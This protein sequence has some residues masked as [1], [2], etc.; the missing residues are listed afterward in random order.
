MSGWA[1]H[2]TQEL[3][4]VEACIEAAITAYFSTAQDDTP[5]GPQDLPRPPK[6]DEGAGPLGEA[7]HRA[8]L[9]VSHRLA[10]GLALLPLLRPEALDMFLLKNQNTDRIFS[11]FCLHAGGATPVRP[12]VGTAVF[13]AGLGHKRQR[14]SGLADFGADSPLFQ[15]HLLERPK[16][17]L[18]ELTMA[19][20]IPAPDFHSRMLFDAPYRP[21]TREDFPAKR[22]CSRL[23][24]D[25]LVLP[26]ETMEALHEILAWL[27]H[28]ETILASDAGRFFTPGYRS[29]FFGPP[30]TGKSLAAT[31]IGQACGRDVYR[32]DLAQ[33]VSKWIG[34]TEKNLAQ[35]Y[36]RAEAQ[37]WILFFDEADALFG[38]RTDVSASNDRYAN[39][40]V[41][42]LLQRIESFDGVVILASNFRGN[43]DAA[44]ARRFQSFVEFRMPDAAARLKLWQTAFPQTKALDPQIDLSRIAQSEELSGGSIMNVA[45]HLYLE[46][47]RAG[48]RQITVHQFHDS[49]GR[50]LLKSGQLR[51]HGL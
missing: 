49:L 6:L 8:G 27:E 45:R 48:A 44:F 10:I 14:I 43:I 32:V 22:L 38:K 35:V 29:L 17:P 31:V 33:T 40:E 50:E 1:P 39:Q 16:T 21:E 19:P 26:P 7:V 9:E 46:M 28:G 42:Y 41:S 15:H 2:L 3:D 25:D 12:T 24:L 4:W 51:G 5:R 37:G 34:E 47:R 11:E 36:E 18:S 13:V 20:L 23:T 30:G